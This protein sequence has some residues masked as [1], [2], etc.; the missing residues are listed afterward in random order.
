MTYDM[1][2]C[3]HIHVHYYSTHIHVCTTH[4]KEIHMHTVDQYDMH[5]YAYII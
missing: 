1:Y 5:S 2:Y 4:M 3:V